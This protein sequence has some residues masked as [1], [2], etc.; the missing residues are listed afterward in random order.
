LGSK[1][2]GINDLWHLLEIF[3]IPENNVISVEAGK[4]VG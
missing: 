1:N 4:V 3:N 2:L